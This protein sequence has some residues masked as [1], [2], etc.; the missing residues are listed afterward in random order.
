MLLQGLPRGI[1]QGLPQALVLPLA[2]LPLQ[3]QV[4][5]LVV[6]QDT[7]PTAGLELTLLLRA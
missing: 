6:L 4:L 3:G 1:V 7:S 5:A 2:L